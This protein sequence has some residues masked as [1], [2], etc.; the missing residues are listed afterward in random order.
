M[1]NKN[2]GIAT[3]IIIILLAI[4]GFIYHNHVSSPV[5][6]SLD[7]TPSVPLEVS[8]PNTTN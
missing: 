3:M 4:I 7:S 1:K 2:V 6:K 8:E 5:A